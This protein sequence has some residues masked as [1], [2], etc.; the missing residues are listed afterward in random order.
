MTTDR[1]IDELLRAEGARWRQGV[2]IDRDVD[3]GVFVE[4]PRRAMRTRTLAG[5]GSVGVL[6]ACLAI[7]LGY[8]WAPAIVPA[9]SEAPSSQA[10]SNAASVPTPAATPLDLRV[11]Q[12]GQ[13]VVATGTL[14]EHKGEHKGDVYLC[15]TRL[16]GFEG[17]IGCLSADLLL[18]RNAQSW[19][20]AVR[21]EGVWTGEAIEAITIER[22]GRP[23]E[24]T[25]PPIPCD[26]P[27]G[28]W[29]GLPKGDEGEAE[30]FALEEELAQYPERY[31]GLWP[32]AN[33]DA[34]GEVT[35]RA[36]V[37]GTV[38]DVE[39]VTAHLTAIYPFNLCVV[40]SEFSTAD[41]RPVAEG[42]AAMDYPWHVDLE[43]RTGRVE[44]WATALSPGMAEA[45]VPYSDE[46]EL[47]TTLRRSTDPDTVR[48]AIVRAVNTDT[49]NF[50]GIYLERGLVIQYVGDNAGRVAI[51]QLLIPGVEVR[52]EQVKYTAGQLRR[53]M[54]EIRER[55][56]EGVVWI[57]LDTIHNQVEVGVTPSGSV[58]EVAQALA[59]YGDAVRV[60]AGA[61]HIV[62]LLLTPAP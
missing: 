51:E 35:T 39:S 12:V 54:S 31:L 33:V 50:G 15:P 36:V 24:P 16:V 18:V 28:G 8:P 57:A 41:L 1:E 30:Y 26:P 22:G 48:D 14:G 53:I 19:R 25:W 42:L 58:S 60:E 2:P 34:A 49:D 5:L 59:T 44:V 3:L 10:P 20:G 61:V 9:G 43:P 47:H 55:H 46:V 45:L 62:P 6:A 4:R 40:H 52:W 11:V 56:L 17:G 21:I 13:A 27:A 23:A 38:D 29:P 32:A 37:V 7:L